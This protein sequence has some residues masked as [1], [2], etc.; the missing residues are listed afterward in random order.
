[1][2]LLS[3][4]L[5]HIN[6]PCVPCVNSE[7]E[8]RDIGSLVVVIAARSIPG[9]DLIDSSETPDGNVEVTDELVPGFKTIFPAV[10]PGVAI[11]TFEVRDTAQVA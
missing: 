4:Y 9:N 5:L 1:M 7:L 2:P 11:L 8:S 6:L 3:Y 10:K